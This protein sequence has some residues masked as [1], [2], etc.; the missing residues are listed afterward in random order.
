MCRNGFLDLK[1]IFLEYNII[2][3]GLIVSEL[4]LVVNFYGYFGGHLENGRK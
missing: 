2:F 1:N 4:C 3:L